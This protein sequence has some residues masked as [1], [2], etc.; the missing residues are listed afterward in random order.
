MVLPTGQFK[1]GVGQPTPIEAIVQLAGV[2]VGGQVTLL[3][4]ASGNELLS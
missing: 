1:S 4:L 3:K 2:D